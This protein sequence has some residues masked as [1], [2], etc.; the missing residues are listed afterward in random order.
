MYR[1]LNLP[2]AY[3]ASLHCN[4]D[5]AVYGNVLQRIP[6]KCEYTRNRLG[7]SSHSPVGNGPLFY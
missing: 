1:A 7:N 4:D 6:Q 5:R 2:N 3:H